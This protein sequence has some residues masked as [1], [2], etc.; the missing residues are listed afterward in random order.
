MHP[1]IPTKPNNCLI[2]ADC[3]SQTSP[4]CRHCKGTLRFR[5]YRT[6]RRASAGT[7]RLVEEDDSCDLRPLR[8]R[9]RQDIRHCRGVL[10]S[11]WLRTE[12]RFRLVTLTRCQVGRRHQ[13]HSAGAA[14]RVSREAGSSRS[15]S[16]VTS[17]MSVATTETRDVAL[18]VALHYVFL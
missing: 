4:P 9:T 2:A 8:V 14:E 12:H 3:N 11:Q 1:P 15:D 7:G 5:W 18:P 13:R 16:N 10:D 6:H 17:R